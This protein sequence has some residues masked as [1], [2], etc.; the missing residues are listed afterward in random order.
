L[1]VCHDSGSALKGRYGASIA[2]TL[3]DVTTSC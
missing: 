1:P 2:D 3:L